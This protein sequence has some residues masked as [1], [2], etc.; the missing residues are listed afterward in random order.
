MSDNETTYIEDVTPSEEP[1]NIPYDWEPIDFEVPEVI[2]EYENVSNLSAIGSDETTITVED[3]NNIL[4]EGTTV[5]VSKIGDSSS[6]DTLIERA[7]MD[8]GD[9]HENVISKTHF[10]IKLLDAFGDEIQPPESVKVK[11]SFKPKTV[12]ENMRIVKVYHTSEDNLNTAEVINTY[13]DDEPVING[14]D[15]ESGE[16]INNSEENPAEFEIPNLEFYIDA[17]SFSYYTVEFSYG[18]TIYKME[19]AALM[20][21]SEIQ[22]IIGLTGTVTAVSFTDPTLVTFTPDG[23][24]D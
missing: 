6:I 22:Q 14:G 24:G 18:P 19:G 8:R 4:P 1:T 3:V 7:L 12:P 2:E 5:K 20:K 21:L 23:N 10:D 13:W 9:G 16:E 17:N 15:N 11:F